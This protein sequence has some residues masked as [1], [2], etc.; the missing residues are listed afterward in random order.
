MKFFKMNLPDQ[1]FG[2]DSG[3]VTVYIQP[4]LLVVII[5][6]SISM[7]VMPRIDEMKAMKRQS[8][9][10]TKK[11]KDL[12]EKVSYLT[13][14][15]QA[16]IKNQTE[17]LESSLMNGRD[18]Y[19]L[20]NIIRKV[21]GK[22]GFTVESFLINPGMIT[23]TEVESKLPIKVVIVG[24]KDKYLELLLAIER[25]LPILS[26]DS[27]SI[28]S[29]GGAV[30]L[31]LGM[32]SYYL[33]EKTAEKSANVSLS[34]LVMKKE[35]SE[36][37]KRLAEFTPIEDTP[38]AKIELGEDGRERRPFVKYEREDPFTP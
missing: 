35:E 7:V 27:F 5:L 34:D 16:E 6:V 2:V 3:L 11:T 1:I 30:E 15:D 28:Q 13:Q 23:Q 17:F 31:T 10:F 8:G 29:S 37:L 32:S 9:D 4:F 24:S 26:I 22:F 19:Y 25:N 33:S 21:V 38:V 20:V 18:S 12:K 14:V 36:V